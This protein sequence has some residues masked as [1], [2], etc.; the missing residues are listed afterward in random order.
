MPRL[1]PRGLPCGVWLVGLLAACV[2]CFASAPRR[3]IDGVRQY[4]LG[5]Y[6]D[7]ALNF[8][9]ALAA[10]PAD[11]DAYY[12]LAATYYAMGR[13]TRDANL[14]MQAEGLYHQSLDLNPEHTS[15]YRGLA[16][17]LV[18]TQRSESAFT[19]LKRWSQRNPQSVDARIELAR[20]YEEFGDK[21]SAAQNLSDALAL[22]SSNARA[23]S[24]LGRIREQQGQ[25]A[26]AL[27]N[28]QQ[29]YQL[30][31]SQPGVG[32][33]IATLQRNV[34]PSAPTWPSQPQIVT[35][36]GGLPPR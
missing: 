3:N 8:Q 4:Q 23:W 30:N 16:A 25:T 6:Q 21:E 1:E 35:A 26:Q 20:L 11:A 12:N 2:G 7:A 18:D 19:L 33:R 36:P 15:C 32:E 14:L 24:A 13:G 5:R 34:L 17:L 27:A 9:R 10:N 22:N 28:Y 31:R 29:S